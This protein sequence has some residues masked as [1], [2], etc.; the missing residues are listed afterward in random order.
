ML[1]ILEQ[2]RWEVQKEHARKNCRKD[3]IVAY[4]GMLY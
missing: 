3:R 4:L 1:A 2:Q